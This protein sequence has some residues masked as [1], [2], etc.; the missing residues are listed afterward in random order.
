MADYENVVIFVTRSGLE[1]TDDYGEYVH[2]SICWCFHLDLDDKDKEI[3]VADKKLVN[4]HSPWSAAVADLARAVVDGQPISHAWRK[5]GGIVEKATW[6]GDVKVSKSFEWSAASPGAFVAELEDELG[7]LEFFGEDGPPLLNL[8]FRDGIG[9]DEEEPDESYTTSIIDDLVC[10]LK[11]QGILDYCPIGPP[12]PVASQENIDCRHCGSH[13][14]M[15]KYYKEHVIKDNNFILGSRPGITDRNRRY[16]A[17][18]QITLGIL[19]G[20]G[21][22]FELPQCVMDGVRDEWPEPCG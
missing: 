8:R 13:I 1:A 5:A 20:R 6:I 9:P 7:R 11:A 14:C 21:P 17:Y 10:Y 12:M 2:F 16:T 22:S 19:Q 3:L 15:W 4:V 18:R